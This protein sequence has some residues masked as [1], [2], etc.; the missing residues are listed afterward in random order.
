MYINDMIVKFKTSYQ[1]L[2][3][4]DKTFNTLR[5]FNLK[6]D[7]KKCALGV[8]ANKF[9]LGFMNNEN[10]IKANP[11]KV[12][13]GSKHVTPL[14]SEGVYKVVNCMVA[15]WRFRSDSA[16]KCFLYFK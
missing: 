6:L 5:R 13:G 3:G 8:L 9:F 1:H 14:I 7:L 2:R 11:K 15:L 10:E 16:H 12:K 4:V